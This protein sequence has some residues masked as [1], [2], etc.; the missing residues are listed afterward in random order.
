MEGGALRKERSSRTT[1]EISTPRPTAQVSRQVVPNDAVSDIFC[2][3]EGSERIER[4]QELRVFAFSVEA[5][6]LYAILQV[7]PNR[8]QRVLDHDDLSG[9][10]MIRRAGTKQKQIESVT[11]FS[12]SA[13]TITTWHEVH[14]DRSSTATGKSLVEANRNSWF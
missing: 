5:G 7:I 8:V 10:V 6:D 3:R 1:S 9:G 4:G 14:D 13:L 11:V 12:I 2:W